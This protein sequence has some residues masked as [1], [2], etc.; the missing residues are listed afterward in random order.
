V[1]IRNSGAAERGRRLLVTGSCGLIGSA[2]TRSFAQRG[3]SITGIDSNHRAVFFGPE[4]DTNWVRGQLES[5]IQDYKHVPMDIRD[6][7]AVLSLIEELRPHL[8]IHAAAQPSHDRAAAIPFL[9]FEVNA[10]GTLHLLE[11]ARRS[12]PESPFIHMSTNK[13]Y[14]DRPNRLPLVEL[15]KRWDYADAIYQHGIAEDFSIDQSKHSLFGAS[16]LASDVMVQEYGRYFGMPTCCL[17]G[18][19]LTG[20]NHAGVELH[21]FLSYL[22]K[23]NVEERE[24]KVFGYK[25]KQVRDNVH[26]DD[27]AAFMYEFWKSPRSAEVYNLGGGKANACSII[28]AFQM[29][30][31]VTGKKMKS[32]YI[33]ENRSGDHICYYSDLRKMQAHYPDWKPLKTLPMIFEEIAGTWSQRLA[34]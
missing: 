26:S 14:G 2:V 10:L 9:D 28:E 17:R 21:G 20:P 32:R 30:E 29:A 33:D 13:V 11:A 4:G 25:G 18:G 16:K 22:L 8:I 27:V 12:C 31:D 15:E 23:C 5:E 7:E 1:Q 34:G 19:C 3:F 6:R 24:Y